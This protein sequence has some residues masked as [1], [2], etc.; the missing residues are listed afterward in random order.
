VKRWH[1]APLDDEEL[2]NLAIRALWE[3]AQR[4]GETPRSY[5]EALFKGMPD[6]ETWRELEP[7]LPP[8]VTNP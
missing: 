8:K 7:L 1:L 4:N 2:G 5:A 6:D 3:L